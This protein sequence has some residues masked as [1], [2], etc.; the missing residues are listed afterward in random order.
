MESDPAVVAQMVATLGWLEQVALNG[1]TLKD[2]VLSLYQWHVRKNLVA[3]NNAGVM[4]AESVLWNLRAAEIM[5]NYKDAPPWIT[6]LRDNL[7][8]VVAN[9]R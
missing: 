4:D 2:R 7:R 3:T 6:K 5:S 9:W 1:P 8:T